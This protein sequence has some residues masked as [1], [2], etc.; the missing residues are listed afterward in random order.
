[1]ARKT[2]QTLRGLES[3]V[4]SAEGMKQRESGHQEIRHVQTC[5]RGETEGSCKCGAMG[6]SGTH[7]SLARIGK[8]RIPRVVY[9][10]VWVC[11]FA[12]KQLLL[13]KVRGSGPVVRRFIDG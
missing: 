1:M 12:C 2:L 3:A 10:C 8:P 11:V 7:K 13:G 4:F 6:A 5:R 9:M